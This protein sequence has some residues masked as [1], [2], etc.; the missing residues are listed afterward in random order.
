[1]AA[2]IHSRPQSSRPVLLSKV[3]GHQDAVSAALLIPKE[4]GVITASE[5]RSGAGVGAGAGAS[6]PAGAGGEGE[7][8]G[9]SSWKPVPRAESSPSAPGT[10]P[11][12]CSGCC[13]GPT[14]AV[15]RGA[16]GVSRRRVGGGWW[17]HRVGELREGSCPT[18]EAL[19]E[20]GAQEGAL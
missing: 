8:W 19:A 13:W 11:L 3:E 20:G 16:A 18:A 12:R 15:G 4:D 14:G 10:E 17:R 9:A 2:E 6:G 7:L 5:D 1:M